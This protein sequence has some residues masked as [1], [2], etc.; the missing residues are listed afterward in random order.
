M[1]YPVK[2]IF[3][4]Q[5]W[6]VN[7]A[8]YSRFGFKGHNGID[9]RIYNDD[10]IKA[11]EG[12]LISPHHGKVIEATFDADGY[13]WYYKIENDK[14]GSILG[15]NTKLFLKVG[16]TVEEGQVIGITGNTGWSTAPHVHWGYYTFPRD[17]Q[18][19]YGGTINQVPLIDE[20]NMSNT[21]EIPID[22]F[23]ELVTKSSK[24][25]AFVNAG[26]SDPEEITKIIN[27]LER[28]LSDCQKEK[29]EQAQVYKDELG[30]CNTII[31]ELIETIEKM[32]ETESPC[33][34]LHENIDELRISIKQCQMIKSIL[35]NGFG[36][37]DSSFESEGAVFSAIEALTRGGNVEKMDTS[38]LLSILWS[39]VLRSLDK[40]KE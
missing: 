39:R 19:G 2:K 28:N 11:S 17:R 34:G 18:N 3:I 40:S 31:V 6:G 37:T 22:T 25:D 23:E 35:K 30:R 10:G 21:I 33:D 7:Q 4:T 27:N 29:D 36:L 1:I 9:L 13:G 24:Y 12:E 5:K 26:Y 8:I 16:D 15:H 14:E 32:E 20:E 38:E